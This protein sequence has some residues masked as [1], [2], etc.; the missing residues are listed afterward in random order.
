M[1]EDHKDQE[2]TRGARSRRQP[3]K[4]GGINQYATIGGAKRTTGDA[5]DVQTSER[6]DV[7]DAKRSSVQDVNVED[8]KRSDV[9]AASIPSVQT[10]DRQGVENMMKVDQLDVQTTKGLNAHSVGGSGVGATRVLSTETSDGQDV[11]SVKRPNVQTSESLVVQKSK[12]KEERIRQTVYLEPDLDEW[13]RDYANKERKHLKRRVEI[14]EV[15]NRA[16]RRMKSE[17]DN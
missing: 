2:E 8:I 11:E 16:L 5:K 1:T 3:P 9:Q 13:V 7:E 12:E 4:I 17:I 15:V 6:L 14:S 10:V